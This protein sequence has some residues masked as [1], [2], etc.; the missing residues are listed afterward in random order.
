MTK[1]IFPHYLWIYSSHGSVGLSDMMRTG[2]DLSTEGEGS[3]TQSYHENTYE[4]KTARITAWLNVNYFFL[5][6]PG[7]M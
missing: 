1:T 6:L 2:S 4:R 5:L 3:R 7:L